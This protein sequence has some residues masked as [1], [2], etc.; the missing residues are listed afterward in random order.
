[1]LKKGTHSFWLVRRHQTI[2]FGCGCYL[3]D[4]QV[5]QQLPAGLS[6]PTPTLLPPTALA[7]AAGLLAPLAPPSAAV[8]A[9]CAVEAVTTL[10]AAADAA[11]V[12]PAVV[13]VGP[14][15]AADAEIDSTVVCSAV[16]IGSPAAEAGSAVAVVDPAVA[17]AV[18]KLAAAVSVAGW[19]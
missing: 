8:I 9:A 14:T 18:K 3:A 7:L 13:E 17:E 6:P 1:M 5:S 15:A 4:E 10:A 19:Y 16:E 2:I 12:D 11:E